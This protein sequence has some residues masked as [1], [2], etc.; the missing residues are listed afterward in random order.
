MIRSNACPRVKIS[1][2]EGNSLIRACTFMM[3]TLK[4]RPVV[5]KWH[6]FA[7]DNKKHDYDIEALNM[8][9]MREVK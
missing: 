1:R 6:D 9:G 3:K 8:C 5:G 2:G 4:T 7:D